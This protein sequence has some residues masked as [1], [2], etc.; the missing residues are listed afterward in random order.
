[1]T[2]TGGPKDGRR[3]YVAEDVV[4]ITV[5]GVPGFYQYDE[6]VNRW[7]AIWTPLPLNGRAT[8]E[9]HG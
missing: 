8:N 4:L 3:Y 2:L 6:E 5:D 9:Q 1:M 7:R